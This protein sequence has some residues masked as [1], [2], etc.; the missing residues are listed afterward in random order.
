[1]FRIATNNTDDYEQLEP[2][3]KRRFDAVSQ[4]CYSDSFFIRESYQRQ[5]VNSSSMIETLT[6]VRNLIIYEK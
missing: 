3:Q 2:L 6:E 1:M 4:L 5:E